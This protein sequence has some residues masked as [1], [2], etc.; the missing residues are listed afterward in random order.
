[1]EEDALSQ[2]IKPGTAEHLAFEHL[3]RVDTAFRG[4]TRSGG[5]P[6]LRLLRYVPDATLLVSS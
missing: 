3:D 6:E 2:E 5:A 4:V 1:M